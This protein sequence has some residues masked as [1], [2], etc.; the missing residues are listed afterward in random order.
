MEKRIIQWSYVQEI[1]SRS[2]EDEVELEPIESSS[3]I[4]TEVV[5]D[6]EVK[7]KQDIVSNQGRSS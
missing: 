1:Y 7:R 4:K 2:G 5:N 6:F 3:D